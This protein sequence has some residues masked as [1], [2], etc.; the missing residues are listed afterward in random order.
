MKRNVIFCSRSKLLSGLLIILGGNHSAFGSEDGFGSRT[1]GFNRAETVSNPLINCRLAS[2]TTFV[3]ARGEPIAALGSDTLLNLEAIVSGKGWTTLVGYLAEGRMNPTVRVVGGVL[4]TESE[5]VLLSE[6]HLQGA[7]LLG[8][9]RTGIQFRV[10]ETVPG[11]LGQEP[12]A[13][14]KIQFRGKLINPV[15]SNCVSGDPAK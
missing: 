4:T 15:F 7:G 6:A 11:P 2:R 8:L 12:Y 1:S 3:D 5:S 14:H 10:I 9:V 13:F